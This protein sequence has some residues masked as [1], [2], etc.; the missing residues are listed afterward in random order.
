MPRPLNTRKKA[1]LRDGRAPIPN[2]EATSKVMSA[3]R[4]KNTGPEV[5]LRQA[6]WRANARGYKV[7]SKD[8]PGR[9]DIVFT[10]KRLAVFV[11]GCFW[12]RCPIC[13]TR[14]PKTHEEFWKNKFEKNT[15]R[16]AKA[17]EDLHALGWRTMIIWECE[18]RDNLNDV[19]NMIKRALEES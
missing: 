8:L 14:T 2:S 10:K 18:V 3:N 1:Y 9:P 17:I 7:N 13:M 16:D 12:H 19:V 6:L 5:N 15:E 11:H 4:G